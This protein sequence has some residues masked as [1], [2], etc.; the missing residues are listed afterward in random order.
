MTTIIGTNGDDSLIGGGEGDLIKGRGGND[1]LKGGSGPDTLFGGTGDDWIYSEG[2]TSGPN[3]VDGGAG[4]DICFLRVGDN[5]S[6]GSGFDAFELN[7]S[8]VTEGLEIDLR[9]MD[10]GGTVTIGATVVTGF[11][12]LNLL[13]TDGADRITVGVASSMINVNGG[14]GDDLIFVKGAA[15]VRGGFDDDTITGSARDN[16]LIA[17]PG[18]DLLIGA[19]GQDTLTGE[20]GPDVLVGMGDLNGG[21]GDD[22]LVV[23]GE[24]RLD[25]A[26]GEDVFVFGN[27]DGLNSFMW[28]PD[29]ADT[30]DVSRV[31]AD[32]TRGGNQ[33]FVMVEAFT[34]H[35]GEV[36]FEAHP[37]ELESYYR[38][39]VDGDGIADA[40]L[41]FGNVVDRHPHFI[42]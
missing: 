23:R 28:R 13:A 4:D 27:L 7:L 37:S 33:A 40:S 41:T 38:F 12:A 20:G 6:G 2:P 25:G 31:D 18:A 39:D 17:G 42:L 24:S 15:Q 29:N 11:E 14:E 3:Q 22:R 32:V 16:I 10:R 36:M 19:G 34:G 5:A 26:G 1:T 9:P 30:I 8:A 21:I 35:T